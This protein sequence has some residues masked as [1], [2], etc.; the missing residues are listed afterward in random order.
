MNKYGQKLEEERGR[1][2]FSPIFNTNL[3]NLNLLFPP[4]QHY[5]YIQYKSWIQ[6]NVHK[7]AAIIKK[8]YIAQH[9][10]YLF[11]RSSSIH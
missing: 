4:G 3:F 2:V 10:F 11:F 7:N 6:R 5:I 8:K 1:N 9:T